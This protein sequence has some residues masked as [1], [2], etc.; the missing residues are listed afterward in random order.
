MKNFKLKIFFVL[1]LLFFLLMGSFVNAQE[2]KQVTNMET[3][4]RAKE[5]KEGTAFPECLG[6]CKLEKVCLENKSEII[7]VDVEYCTKDNLVCC[8][9]D[10]KTMEKEKPVIKLEVEIPGIGGRVDNLGNY[11]A[12]IYK[13]LVYLAGIIAVIVIM[14]AGFQWISAGGNANQIGDAKSR[15]GGAI[16]GLVLALSSYLILNTI[17]PELVK[18][19]SLNIESII[20]V[21]LNYKSCDFDNGFFETQNLCNCGSGY[22]EERK[23]LEGNTYCCKCLDPNGDIK[24][25]QG[26]KVVDSSDDCESR[27]F[28][29]IPSGKYCC[30]NEESVLPDSVCTGKREW[31]SCVKNDSSPGYCNSDL[32][33][34]SCV[35]RDGYCTNERQCLGNYSGAFKCGDTQWGLSCSEVGSQA[36]KRC[37]G[38]D[39]VE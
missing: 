1:S 4:K 21:P 36:V 34:I 29:L 27:R 17:N 26:Y 8:E 3:F 33:C 18:I 14:I 10:S 7:I 39:A 15:I 9:S 30:S 31:N 35:V 28:Y 25:T 22:I 19:K 6:E 38:E 16:V 23:L 24:C 32:Q 12:A 5:A 11:I 13:F 37:Q 2:T 20:S